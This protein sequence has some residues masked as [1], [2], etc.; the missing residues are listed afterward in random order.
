VKC[1]VLT[2]AIMKS[3][4]RST[5]TVHLTGH[6]KHAE[7]RLYSV[8]SEICHLTVMRCGPAAGVPCMVQA[9]RRSHGHPRGKRVAD[10][11]H[12]PSPRLHA[13]AGQRARC[14]HILTSAMSMVLMLAQKLH[15]RAPDASCPHVIR[16]N[17]ASGAAGAERRHA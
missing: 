1:T 17:G 12:R 2:T 4:H 13:R 10:V 5:M 3:C 15:I 6:T 11:A 9:L 7:R 14:P 8:I 16:R